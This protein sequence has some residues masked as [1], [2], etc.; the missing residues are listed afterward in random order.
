MP[1]VVQKYGGTSLSTEQNRSQ[2]IEKVIKEKEAGNDVVVVVSAMGRKGDT[3]ATDTL[4]DKLREV[5][6]YP[7]ARTKDLMA[8]CGE[9]IS[10]CIL[11]QSLEAKGYAALPLTG[12]QAGI[13]TNDDFT[14]GIV[15]AVETER[16]L[17]VINSGAIAVV[18]GFQGWNEQKDVVTLGRGGSD[19]TAIALGGTLQA[20]K[21]EIYTDVP[22]IAY[23]DPRIIPSAPFLQSIDFEPMYIL[24][25]TGAKV[26]NH[27]AVETAINFQRPFWVRST[28]SEAPGTLIGQKGEAPG[29]LYGMSLLKDVLLVIRDQ[30]PDGALSGLSVN[31]WFYRR[32]PKRTA[33]IIEP[34]QADRVPEDCQVKPICVITLQW[35]CA[36]GISPETVA[37]ALDSHG[38][39]REAY[40]VVP[41]GGAWAVEEARSKE[42]MLALYR[43]PLVNY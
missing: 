34:E 37:T 40:F 27:R 33:V 29:G 5:S 42:A 7:S 20:D 28:F 30:D 2:V 14:N 4:L 26:V 41:G 24:A 32:H 17:Q 12:F 31:E 15:T 35:D 13:K 21:V 23:T 22:G 1:L 9:I 39:V 10:A 43:A 38:I 18:A 36:A 11:A 8:S 16:I 25:R 6:S 19:T 3:Y